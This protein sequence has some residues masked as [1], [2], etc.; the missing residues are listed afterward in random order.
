MR[1]PVG[2]VDLCLCSVHPKTCRPLIGHSLNDM[3]LDVSCFSLLLS[4]KG[5]ELLFS[6]LQELRSEYYENQNQ[7]EIIDQESIYIYGYLIHFFPFSDNGRT[8]LPFIAYATLWKIL[9][10]ITSI[11]L[12]LD[13][14]VE[15][16]YI[17]QGNPSGQHRKNQPYTRR[18]EHEEIS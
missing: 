3:F 12:A 10:K 1:V 5:A 8:L 7:M 15:Y 11:Q 13:K 17:N 6:A 4:E 16:V 2:I 9:T 14:H 18:I